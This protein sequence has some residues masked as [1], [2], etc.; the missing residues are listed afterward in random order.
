M[1]R[2]C[3]VFMCVFLFIIIQVKFLGETSAGKSTLINKILEKRIFKGRNNESTSTICKIRNSAK[4][5]ILT[6]S[7]TGQIDETDLTEKDDVEKALRDSLKKLTDMTS[8]KECIH[9]RSV[10]IGFPIPFL[11]VNFTH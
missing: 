7:M 1:F 2:V 6:E 10:D 8:S 4:T 3:F 5:R 9:F 11:K